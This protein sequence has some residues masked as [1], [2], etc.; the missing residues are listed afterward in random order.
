MQGGL[1]PR[2]PET[3]EGGQEVEDLLLVGV[4]EHVGGLL[5]PGHPEV[6]HLLKKVNQAYRFGR[7]T[8]LLTH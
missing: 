8:Y 2:G 7:L 1:R 5:D 6:E 4:L 3:V